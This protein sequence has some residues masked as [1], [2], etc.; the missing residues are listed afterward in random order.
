MKKQLITLLVLTCFAFVSCDEE[1]VVVYDVNNGQTIGQITNGS[2]QTLPVPDTGDTAEIVVGVTTISTIDRTVTIT[3]VDSLTTATPAE[4]TIDPASLVIPA[5]E[6]EARIQVN[7]NFD[8]I[9][10]TGLSTLAINVDAIQGADNLE[11]VLS[12]QINFFRFCPFGEGATFT[13]DYEI[14]TL[15]TG[16]FD[17]TTLTDGIVTISQGTT[18]ADRVFSVAAYP[19]FGD[20]PPFTFSFSLICGEVVVQAV[21]NINVGCGGGNAIGPSA[22]VVS[23]YDE[24]D[25]SEFVINFVDDVRGQ[26]EDT[27]YEVSIRLTKQ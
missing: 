18:V 2:Q 20:F 5:G 16:I 10:E 3:V 6:F 21:D 9:P 4:Y 13:G 7:A 23:T 17:V 27:S 15:T 11:G 12:H 25:D 26:C 1:E 14:E 24:N 8:A 22:T 19:A